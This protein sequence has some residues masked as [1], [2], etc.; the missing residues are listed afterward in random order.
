MF[1]GWLR[2]MMEARIITGLLG[3]RKLRRACQRVPLVL[4]LL[5]VCPAN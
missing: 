1:T 5:Q 2:F 3:C 4:A